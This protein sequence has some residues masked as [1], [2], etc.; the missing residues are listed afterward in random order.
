VADTVYE[1]VAARA[2]EIRE[3]LRQLAL[4]HGELIYKNLSGGGVVFIGPSHWWP[5]LGEDGRRLQS[6]VRRAFGELMDLVDALLLDLPE[7]SASEVANARERVTDLIDRTGGTWSKSVAEALESAS[8][9]LTEIIGYV[10]D[11]YDGSEGSPIYVPDTNALL[12]NPDLDKWRF[13]RER[14]TLLLAPLVLSELDRLKVEHRNPDVR[15]KADG[16]I[17]RLKGYRNRADGDLRSGVTLRKDVSILRSIA[18]E[19]QMERSLSWLDATSNDDRLIAT[20][21]EVMRAHVRSPV[22]LVTRDLNMQNKAAHAAIP[23]IE[24]PTPAETKS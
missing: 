21:I 9:A 7:S 20:V 19:P 23:F 8:A 12:A 6:R 14:F 3:L 24:P 13:G 10:S 11:L 5:A 2:D 4:D 22:T 1:S 15:A 17:T 18:P 16:L